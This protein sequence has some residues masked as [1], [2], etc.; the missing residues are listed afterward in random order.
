MTQASNLRAITTTNHKG[1]DAN[2]WRMRGSR[3]IREFARPAR[4]PCV[5]GKPGERSL[6]SRSRGLAAARLHE[7]SRN[8]LAISRRES[9]HRFRSFRGLRL[10][11]GHSRACIS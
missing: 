5:V 2:V 6:S 11:P 9:Q 4:K 1:I 3:E 10:Q 7:F 8:L